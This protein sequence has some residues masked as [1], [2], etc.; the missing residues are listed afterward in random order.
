[1]CKIKITCEKAL[2]NWKTIITKMETGVI[3]PKWWLRN[4]LDDCGSVPR[5]FY[6]RVKTGPF[7]A[8]FCLSPKQSQMLFSKILDKQRYDSFID[9]PCSKTGPLTSFLIHLQNGSNPTMC[10]T[11]L[12]KYLKIN[13]F[14]ITC[15]I[16]WQL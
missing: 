10:W 4:G 14:I 12:L 7:S 13:Y 16:H 11:D 1:M 15:R 5:N 2:Q 3:Q 6:H 8:R 9:F